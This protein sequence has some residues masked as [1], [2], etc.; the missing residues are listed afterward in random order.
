[1][2][3]AQQ[4]SKQLGDNGQLWEDDNGISLC[5]LCNERAHSRWIAEHE[6]TIYEFED[7]S[8]IV[9]ASGGWDL[10][11]DGCKEHCWAGVGCM[12]KAY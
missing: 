4:I 3:V 2:T 1:M 10:R 5:H 8:A 6:I 9:I 12:C 11:P 7:D